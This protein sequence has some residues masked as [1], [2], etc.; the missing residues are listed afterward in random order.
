M[1]K[2]DLPAKFPK[3]QSRR[4]GNDWVQRSNHPILEVPSIITGEPNYVLNP[5]HSAFEKIEISDSELFRF[6]PRI[7]ERLK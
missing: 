7:L 5:N 2:P 3:S 1:F 6:D 4:I